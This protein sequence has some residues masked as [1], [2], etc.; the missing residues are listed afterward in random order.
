MIIALHIGMPK[1][2]TTTLQ[3][4]FTHNAKLLANHGI[5]YPTQIS[6]SAIN[7]RILSFFAMDP[8]SYPRHMAAF[9]DP[10]I[11][12]LLINEFKESVDKQ[13]RA[14]EDPTYLVF[15]AE[16]LFTRIRAHKRTSFN[17]YIYSLSPQL[18]LSLYLRSPSLFYLSIC[19]QKLR[20]SKVPS[21]VRPPR[22]KQVI[23]S[24][25][26]CFPSADCH[27]AIY[28][29]NALLNSDIVCDFC[30][31][32]FNDI[33]FNPCSLVRTDDSNIS[34]SG[35]S[36]AILMLYR[37]NFLPQL[38]DIHV[39]SSNKLARLLSRADQSCLAPKATLRSEIK[40]ELERQAARDLIWLRETLNITFE[41]ICYDDLVPLP[42]M[43]KPARI[44]ASLS[45]VMN[46]NSNKFVDVIDYLAST[47]F[48]YL[49]E[50]RLNW[51]MSLRSLNL[52]LI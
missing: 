32:I 28:E 44:P 20:A 40:H 8:R 45:E 46:L 15:S 34:L 9:R 17:S 38:D 18:H 14:I 47:R 49:S 41:D 11:S 52:S 31:R 29:R 30:T 1:T 35:E 6:S 23:E 10:S 33:S 25:Q 5:C 3:K 13:I 12:N 36:M 43:H 4:T 26:Q 27:V 39:K 37:R 51:L 48:F 19:Q 21:I 50:T 7:H 16:S 42:L 22:Y 24:Y 2:G